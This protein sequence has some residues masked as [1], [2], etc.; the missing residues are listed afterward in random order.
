MSAAQHLLSQVLALP[1]SERAELAH[2]LLQSLETVPDA[3][4]EAEWLQEIARRAEGVQNG[5]VISV[6]WEA[7]REN[8]MG[9]LEK[10]RAARRSS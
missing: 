5:S 3:D 6:P 7:A 2:R 4:L 9:E 8:I 10:R 1:V